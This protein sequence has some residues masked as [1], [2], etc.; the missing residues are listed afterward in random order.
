MNEVNSHYGIRKES[1]QKL[2]RAEYRPWR[3]PACRW[4]W[5]ATIL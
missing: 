2:N 4:R 3:S 5:R 1:R